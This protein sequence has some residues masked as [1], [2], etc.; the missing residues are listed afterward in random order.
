[1][2]QRLE[3]QGLLERVLG[4][5]NVYFQPP[6]NVKMKYPAIV[7]SLD[8][9]NHLHA[10]NRPYIQNPAFMITLIDPDPTS[11]YVK[12]LDSLEKC[13]F[14]RFYVADNLN[15]WVFVKYM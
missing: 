12:E 8:D 6:E 11:K 2:D 7:Y 1:M 9:I 4:S 15:H 14:E 3:L 10:N 5:Q 13:S